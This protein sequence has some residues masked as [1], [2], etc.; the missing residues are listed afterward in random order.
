[1]HMI[2]QYTEASEATS[3]LEY[4][5]G[6]TESMCIEIEYLV[7]PSNRSAIRR[8]YIKLLLDVCTKDGFV[9]VTEENQQILAVSLWYSPLA[10]I[11]KTGSIPERIRQAA[12]ETGIPINKKALSCFFSAAEDEINRQAENVIILAKM[13][14][15]PRSRNQGYAKEHIDAVKTMSW[16]TRIV[17]F[18]LDNKAEAKLMNG[19]SVHTMKYHDYYVHMFRSMDR[20]E[21]YQSVRILFNRREAYDSAVRIAEDIRVDHV[22]S[23]YRICHHEWE[24]GG[25]PGALYPLY[26]H[27]IDLDSIIVHGEK[28]ANAFLLSVE[29]LFD[30]GIYTQKTRIEIE[31]SVAVLHVMY[32]TPHQGYRTEIEQSEIGRG[33]SANDYPDTN[34]EYDIHM[35]FPVIIREKNIG[36]L[37]QKTS[38]YIRHVDDSLISKSMKNAFHYRMDY[39]HG[40][41]EY[42]VFDT[43]QIHHRGDKRLEFLCMGECQLSIYEELLFGERIQDA[44]QI[45]RKNSAQVFLVKDT[46]SNCGVFIVTILSSPYPITQLLD[47]LSRNQLIVDN[48]NTSSNLLECMKS[49]GIHAV[50][51]PKSIITA[52]RKP[53]ID[54][55]KSIMFSETYYSDSEGIGC[56]IDE[57]ISRIVKDN[58]TSQYSYSSVYLYKSVMIQFPKA[59]D[60]RIV[61][62]IVLQSIT[63]YYVATTLMYESAINHVNQTLATL[64][65]QNKGN[66]GKVLRQLNVINSDFVKTMEFWDLN[67]NYVSSQKS[68]EMIRN[69]FGINEQRT[70]MD[71]NNDFLNY[72]VDIQSNIVEKWKSSIMNALL[73]ALTVVGVMDSFISKE[74]SLDKLFG[75]ILIVLCMQFALTYTGRKRLRR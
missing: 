27:E 57:D 2:R 49:S 52:Y 54:I 62:R 41:S 75:A 16:N 72:M 39:E 19:F 10:L 4:L 5:V 37:R 38:G 73:L 23:I 51:R 45:A 17:S 15:E 58:G 14:V 46:Q 21:P 3:L 18:H 63:L 33:D 34:I 12:L 28:A 68:V 60:A 64:L 36:Q 9:L 69:A 43:E 35:C 31:G 61:K 48:V 71:R 66:T 8:I 67:V 25:S 24:S 74:L 11:K 42:A 44:T 20:Q 40:V 32:S 29:K 13:Y 53:G 55:L 22:K 50:G 47:A 26:G 56:V 59:V 65:A 70:I 30:L 1:M 7:S 6:C